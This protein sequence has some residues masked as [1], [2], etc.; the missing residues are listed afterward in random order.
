[1]F[2]RDWSS[3]VCSSDLSV[4]RFADAGRLLHDVTADARLCDSRTI[5]AAGWSARVMLEA[6]T[7]RLGAALAAAS[8]WER[9]GSGSRIQRIA[10]IG[11]ASCRESVELVS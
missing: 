3:D 9:V 8:A 7:G 6:R 2:S 11:R 5:Q 4:E 10:E 1:R